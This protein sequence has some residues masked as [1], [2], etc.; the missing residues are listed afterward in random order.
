MLSLFLPFSL[1]LLLS[2]SPFLSLVSLSL[3]FLFFT[4]R[5]I[6]PM[7]TPKNSCASPEK[8][9]SLLS[10]G[11]AGGECVWFA[12]PIPPSLPFP[13]QLTSQDEAQE[14]KSGRYECL[15]SLVV[16]LVDATHSQHSGCEDGG[17]DSRCESMVCER[18]HFEDIFSR[19][20]GMSVNAFI[21]LPHHSCFSLCVSLATPV[22]SHP[23]K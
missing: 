19:Y 13:H 16:V 11:V 14:V 6:T 22:P 3:L 18:Y 10:F 12:L 2:L 8:D 21:L 15:F 1:A 4:F 20:K 23:H 5:Y 7:R 17:V 9:S